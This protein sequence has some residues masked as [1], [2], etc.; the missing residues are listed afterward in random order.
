MNAGPPL[1][2]SHRGF[3]PRPRCLFLP[4]SCLSAP[5]N[6]TGLTPLSSSYGWNNISPLGMLGR[7]IVPAIFENICQTNWIL[8]PC[9][10]FFYAITKE[11]AGLANK[12]TGNEEWDVTHSPQTA[13]LVS[14][15]FLTPPSHPPPKPPASFKAVSRPI[16]CSLCHQSRPGSRLRPGSQAH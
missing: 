4:S 5:T 3:L 6:T 12:E 10:V 9:F 14:N 11:T 15:S 13:S 7:D 2:R 16:S 1:P 8:C